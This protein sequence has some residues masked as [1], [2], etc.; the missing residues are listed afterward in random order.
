MCIRIYSLPSILTAYL[1]RD[2][3]LAPRRQ[4]FKPDGGSPQEFLKSKTKR[5]KVKVPIHHSK[6]L[7][8]LVETALYRCNS[9]K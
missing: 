2:P 8:C 4:V 9:Q 7:P 5:N 1:S 6:R 3:V